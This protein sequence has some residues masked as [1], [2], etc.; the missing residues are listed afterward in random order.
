MIAIMTEL[1]GTDRRRNMLIKEKKDPGRSFDRPSC[2]CV[3]V[4]GGRLKGGERTQRTGMTGD[5]DRLKERCWVC[6][7]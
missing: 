7:L 2:V 5:T 6:V 4:W 1:Q 3:R